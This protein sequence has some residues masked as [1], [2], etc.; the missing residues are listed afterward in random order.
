[1]RLGIIT[2]SF[3]LFFTGQ[4]FSQK[5][6]IELDTIM[7]SKNWFNDLEEAKANPDKVYYLDL[8]LQKLRTFPKEILEFKNVKKLFLPYNYWSSIPDEIG[9]LSKVET[10][11][12]SGNYYMNHLPAGLGKLK[13][14]KEFTI[15]DHKLVAGEI[16][17]FRKMLPS[18]KV[19]TD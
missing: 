16:E 13:N 11:D 10:L 1:M 2:F 17:K 12:L 15:K 7:F 19:L 4:A 3:I 5:T 18:C 14:L 9:T 6:E 8:S